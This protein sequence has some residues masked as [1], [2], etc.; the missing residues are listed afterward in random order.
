[1]AS[2][3]QCKEVQRWCCNSDETEGFSKMKKNQMMLT[4]A[5]V[6][7][8]SMALLMAG[9]AHATAKSSEKIET[10]DLKKDA[11]NTQ[12]VLVSDGKSQT[13]NWTSAQLA[14]PVA[15]EKALAEVPEAQRDNIQQLLSQVQEGKGLQF[16]TPDHGKVTVHHIGP[17]ADINELPHKKVIMHKIAGGDGTEFGLLK[18][19]LTESKLSKAQLQEL[20]KVLDSKY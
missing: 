12:L 17:A 19:L 2:K 14:D 20:Q 13:F 5:K 8:L 6:T 3:F 16:V 10:I 7:A 18:S 15:L 11:D 4:L 1:L 9:C